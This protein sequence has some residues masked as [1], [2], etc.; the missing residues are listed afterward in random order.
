LK[1][2]LKNIS[3]LE[4]FVTFVAVILVLAFALTA[5]DS[6][7]EELSDTERLVGDWSANRVDLEISPGVNFELISGNVPGVPDVTAVTI[8]YTAA[9]AFQLQIVS[10]D[11]LLA[12]LSGQYTVDE[13]ANTISHTNDTIT[14]ALVMT[15]TFNTADN[16]QLNFEGADLVTLGLDIPGI[17][18][19]ALGGVS[20]SFDRQ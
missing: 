18:E 16:V 6:G 17:D 9:N 15:Y 8:D 19:S 13:S 2:S 5:C 10:P 3:A 11:S 20:G 14:E 4:N 7:G 1:R 12:D